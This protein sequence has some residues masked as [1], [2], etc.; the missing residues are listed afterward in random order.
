MGRRQPQGYARAVGQET[1]AGAL[2]HRAQEGHLEE[3]QVPP[4]AQGSDYLLGGRHGPQ[5]VQRLGA[6]GDTGRADRP[7]PC[8][9]AEAAGRRDRGTG[10]GQARARQFTMGQSGVADPYGPVG[11][12]HRPGGPAGR[13]VG[14]RV[15]ASFGVGGPGDRA[16]VTGRR[17]HGLGEQP[18]QPQGAVRAVGL[19]YRAAQFGQTGAR[20]VRDAVGGTEGG[21]QGGDE[22]GE[23]VRRVGGAGGAHPGHHGDRRGGGAGQTGEAGGVRGAQQLRLEHGTGTVRA[24]LEDGCRRGVHGPGGGALFRGG[25]LGGFSGRSILGR[26]RS[27]SRSGSRGRGILAGVGGRSVLGG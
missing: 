10:H 4:A 3:Q 17:E 18:V 22:V 8:P 27:R 1:V 9:G 6:P 5:P 11:C 19:P 26:S 23:A 24:G 7:Y 13:H 15:Q 2:A 21:G 25:L 14:H 16:R 20:G 12:A